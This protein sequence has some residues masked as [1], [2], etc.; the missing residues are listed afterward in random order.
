M[1]TLLTRLFFR[2]PLVLVG[3]VYLINT[4][5]FHSL[6]LLFL[7]LFLNYVISEIGRINH[8]VTLL[9]DCKIKLDNTLKK[10]NVIKLDTNEISDSISEM[11]KLILKSRYSW[12]KRTSGKKRDYFFNKERPVD[13]LPIKIYKIEDSLPFTYR[14]YANHYTWNVIITNLGFEQ[15]TATQKFLI[16]HEIGHSTFENVLI[17]ARRFTVK[18]EG[19]CLFLLFLFAIGIK[20]QLVIYIPLVFIFFLRVFDRA[21]LKSEVNADIWALHQFEKLT[22]LER[23]SKSICFI[24]NLKVQDLNFNDFLRENLEYKEKFN[25]IQIVNEETKQRIFSIQEYVK[26]RVSG[27]I[28]GLHKTPPTSIS[29]NIYDFI[30]YIA[31]IYLAFL[32]TK[33]NLLPIIV[34]SI[35]LL[36]WVM[37]IYKEVDKAELNFVTTLKKADANNI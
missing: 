24:L 12:I 1:L 15:M 23:I 10:S 28:S 20:W 31:T 33:V 6:L 21:T 19:F 29:I 17:Y 8:G 37:L 13:E 16:L 2:P 32:I 18:I 26:N 34:I 22:D 3:T 7:L 27:R 30:F 36:F 14:C 11:G 5:T 9:T 35:I 4:W 25:E